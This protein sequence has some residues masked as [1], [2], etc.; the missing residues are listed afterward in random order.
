MT[1]QVWREPPLT[2]AKLRPPATGTGLDRLIVVPSP[3]EPGEDRGQDACA[4]V[5]P[6]EFA[7]GEALA[8]SN[9]KQPSRKCCVPPRWDPRE[10]GSAIAD[11]G[12]RRSGGVRAKVRGP[13]WQQGH[14]PNT[15]NVTGWY[16][17]PQL[18]VRQRGAP[19]CRLLTVE[20]AE[21]SR[22]TSYG[23]LTCKT[24][25]MA[26]ARTSFV[27]AS[28]LLCIQTIC[29]KSNDPPKY[30]RAQRGCPFS[31]NSYPKAGDPRKS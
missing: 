28:R 20:G 13:A 23:V 10:H 30:C 22:R 17:T 16:C 21:E 3:G 24:A 31:P 18:T 8:L 2:A 6:L 19:W 9:E 26:A 11:S 4:Y 25:V 1:P 27:L 14:R 15:V 7:T 29:V 5:P 12:R